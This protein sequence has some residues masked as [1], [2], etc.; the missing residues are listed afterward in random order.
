MNDRDCKTCVY[1][2][3]WTEHDNGCTAWECEYINRQEAI[4]GYKNWQTFKAIRCET[5]EHYAEKTDDAMHTHTVCWN[6]PRGWPIRDP[7]DFCSYWQ[8]KEAI[9]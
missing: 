1:S 5:C 7:D 6:I 8:R 4:E 9:E 3:G 2:V